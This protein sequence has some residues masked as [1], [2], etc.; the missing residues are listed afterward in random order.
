ML[1]HFLVE[2]RDYNKRSLL[3]FFILIALSTALF[4]F[5]AHAISEIKL[6]DHVDL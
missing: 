4:L 1:Q 6:R 3:L 5:A 2:A